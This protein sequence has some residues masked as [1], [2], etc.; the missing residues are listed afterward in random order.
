VYRSYYELPVDLPEYEPISDSAASLTIDQKLG[1]ALR[2]KIL[3]EP[4]PEAEEAISL[5]ESLC[6]LLADRLPLWAS[7]NRF[8]HAL[9]KIKKYRNYLPEKC[10]EEKASVIRNRVSFRKRIIGSLKFT[11]ILV[12]YSYTVLIN[13]NTYPSME[14]MAGGGYYFLKIWISFFYVISG[15]F[16]NYSEA[17][18]L[19]FGNKKIG[20]EYYLVLSFNIVMS[21]VLVAEW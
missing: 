1:L 11:P 10:A 2:L 17:Y 4:S 18:K 21:I 20:K 19:I 3:A 16:L 5:V 9:S 6:G 8:K 14:K 15:L 7:L 12:L 13:N